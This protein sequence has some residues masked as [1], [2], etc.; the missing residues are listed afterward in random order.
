MTSS[1]TEGSRLSA[2]RVTVVAVTRAA[3]PSIGTAGMRATREL[4]KT[5]KPRGSRYPIEADS[6]R[7]AG[8]AIAGEV[9][10]G[11]GAGDEQP[12]GSRAVARVE[13]PHV[14]ANDPRD[15]ALAGVE[16]RRRGL[17]HGLVDLRCVLG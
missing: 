8:A 13:R 2:N 15:L 16:A 4:R 5:G 11:K 10:L 1:S 7:R 6:E 3:E 17:P 14:G 12:A 9:D